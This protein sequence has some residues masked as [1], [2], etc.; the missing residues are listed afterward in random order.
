MVAREFHAD[1]TP[2][3]HALLWL[4]GRV[5]LRS[6]R[7][8]DSILGCHG[9]YVVM[10]DP[11][12]SVKYLMKGSDY[13][14]HGFDP[15]E[16]V[17]SAARHRPRS[18]A[19]VGSWEQATKV[20]QS[21]GAIADLPNQAFVMRNLRKLAAYASWWASQHPHYRVDRTDSGGSVIKWGVR[22]VVLWGRTGVGKSYWARRGLHGLLGDVYVLPYQREG[23][24][25]WDGY[26]GERILLLDDFDPGK[27][28]ILQLLRVLDSYKFTGMVKGDTVTADWTEVIITN[29]IPPS[30]W[31][32]KAS[33]ERHQA[34]ERRLKVCWLGHAGTN[35]SVRGATAPTFEQL[36]AHATWPSDE[37]ISATSNNLEQ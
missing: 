10:K 22:T 13:C 7:S 25:W 3:L 36:Y 11:V 20:L 18:T 26:R 16:Y 31:Y 19:A 21:G 24:V 12:A 32:P 4:R 37:P 27:M 35:W 9:N 29:N 15:A 14:S 1:G 28:P 5:D 17:A 2:H 6:F 23:G 33:F 30:R 34:L 8:L